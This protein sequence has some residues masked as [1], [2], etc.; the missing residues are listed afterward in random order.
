MRYQCIV[1]F[2]SDRSK[3]P[4]NWRTSSDGPDVVSAA[5]RAIDALRRRQ[6]RALHVIGIYLHA[7]ETDIAAAPKKRSRK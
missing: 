4:S 3:A 6:R 7:Q 2:R 1:T 5:T